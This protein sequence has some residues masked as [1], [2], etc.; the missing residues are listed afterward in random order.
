MENSGF[1]QDGAL[2]VHNEKSKTYLNQ[3]LVIFT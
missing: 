2:V 1:P 3:C